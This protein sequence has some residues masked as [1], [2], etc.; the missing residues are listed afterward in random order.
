MAL[1][2][3]LMRL[4]TMMEWIFHSGAPV[5]QSDDAMMSFKMTPFNLNKF[6]DRIFKLT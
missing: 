3:V 2:C 1:Y 6:K 5:A 4:V